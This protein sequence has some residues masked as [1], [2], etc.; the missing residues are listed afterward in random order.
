MT[1]N[2]LLKEYAIFEHRYW[3]GR[4]LEE[5]IS[6]ID[7]ALIQLSRLI[8]PAKTFF[9]NET[10]GV[11]TRMIKFINSDLSD[12]ITA[13]LKDPTFT[14]EG[15]VKLSDLF[16]AFSKELLDL[17][18]SETLAMVVSLIGLENLK[19]KTNLPFL[20]IVD[21]QKH[22]DLLKVL[23][24][25]VPSVGN[26]P[27]KPPMTPDQ[28]AIDYLNMSFGQLTPIA[29]SSS[30]VSKIRNGMD[31]IAQLHHDENSAPQSAQASVQPESIE[32][33]IMNVKDAFRKAFGVIP[34]EERK[35]IPPSVGVAMKN[36]WSGLDLIGKQAA[37]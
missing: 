31:V 25:K 33:A 32:Q 12:L 27:T 28:I 21:R 9:N 18:S 16:K 37:H 35:R 15:L 14:D 3:M 5:Q 11:S 30:K 36:F 6:D 23:K 29:I 2:I 1:P 24:T 13:Y 7:E 10:P 34:V 19:G 4:I 20:K 8:V 22:W 17:Y 26:L